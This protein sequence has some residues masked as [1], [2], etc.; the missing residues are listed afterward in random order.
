[1]LLIN[2]ANLYFGKGHVCAEIDPRE[3]FIFSH[4]INRLGD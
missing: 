2:H 3:M 4:E 1:M